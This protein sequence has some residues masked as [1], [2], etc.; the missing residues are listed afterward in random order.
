AT[1]RAPRGLLVRASADACEPLARRLELVGCRQPFRA[2]PRRIDGVFAGLLLD[3]GNERLADLVLAHL[4][5][6]A[7]E[8]LEQAADPAGASARFEHPRHALLSLHAARAELVHHPVAV[9][10]EQRHERLHPADGPAVLRGGE[11]RDEPTV[12]ERVAP[13]PE[14]LERG[15]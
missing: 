14:L 3:R 7:D 12:V 4:R 10:L 13:L 6:E 9:P 1:A 5:L 8:L 2:A 11:Q 15:A